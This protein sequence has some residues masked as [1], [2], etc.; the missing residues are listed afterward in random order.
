[1]P[2]TDEKVRPINFFGSVAHDKL[3]ADDF[4]AVF[5]HHFLKI[6]IN[7]VIYI[8]IYNLLSMCFTPLVENEFFYEGN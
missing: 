5:L 8:F 6:K 2:L 1:M 3:R 4:A 7:I